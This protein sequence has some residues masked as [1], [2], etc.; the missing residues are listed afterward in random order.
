MVDLKTIN[1]LIDDIKK[2][3]KEERYN[4]SISVYHECEYFASKL[5]LS[6]D[7]KNTLFKAAIL[8]DIAKNVTVDKAKSLCETIGIEYNDTPVLHQDIGAAYALELYGNEIVDENVCSAISKHTTGGDNMNMCD[9]VL[10]I[11]DYSEPTRK[12]EICI[13]TR[14]R[15]HSK[16]DGITSDKKACTICLMEEIL[17]ISKQT[18][19][20]LLDKRFIVD[21]RT[22]KTY[23]TMTKILREI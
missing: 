4:H 13:Q 1:F 7:E 8:H 15:I 16:L 11:A 18:I 22:N 20:H 6:D 9:M 5:K 2:Y 17:E 10:F 19:D 3:E 12:H 23:E 21:D 14:N